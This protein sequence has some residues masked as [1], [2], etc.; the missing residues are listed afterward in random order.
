VG[1]EHAKIPRPAQPARYA[2]AQPAPAAP[3]A[4]ATP[5]AA[6]G[7]TIAPADRQTRF[8]RGEPIRLT[9]TASHDAHVYC[10]LQDENAQIRRFYP[11]RF[12]RD[13]L[14]PANQALALPG[15]MRFQLVMNSKGEKE[16]VLCFATARD[17]LQQLPN[18]VVGVDFE[19]LPVASL[20]QIRD[21]FASASGGLLAQEFFHVQP[22]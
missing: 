19:A 12:A 1:A 14:L 13:S 6:L 2:A 5:P 9:L 7:L 20:D 18:N 3:Q 21:A 17:I 4:A 15:S 11:N 10:Y 16:T 22:K 8:G